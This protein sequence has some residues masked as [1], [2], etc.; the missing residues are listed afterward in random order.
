MIKIAATVAA[1]G[2]GLALLGT[3]HTASNAADRDVAVRDG[4]V[5]D[6]VV[7]KRRVRRGHYGCPDGY[8]CYPL[9]GAYG[10]YGGR[11][12]WSSFSYIVPSYSDRVVLR[13][14]Y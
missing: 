14:R 6:R 13:S 9:Y 3:T 7:V 1:F 12:Y 8:G 11:A 2:L 4:A 10:P 5:S